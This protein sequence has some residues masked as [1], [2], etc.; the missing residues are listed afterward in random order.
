MT[1]K[2]WN[3]NMVQAEEALAHL[4][5][6]PTTGHINWGEIDVAHID[7]GCTYHPVFGFDATNKSDFLQLDEGVNH[8]E[9]GDLP[10]DPLDYPGFPGH[11]TRTGSV[12]CGSLP[13][14]HTGVAPRLPTIPYP[15]RKQRPA[16]VEEIAQPRRCVH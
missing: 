16:G 6:D 2:D 12:L 9:P 14:T 4:P 10:I 8:L 3:L 1:A 15:G 11:G 13:G 5:T 7:T